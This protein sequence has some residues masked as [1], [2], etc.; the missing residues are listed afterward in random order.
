MRKNMLRYHISTFILVLIL[1]LSSSFSLIEKDNSINK[2]VKLAIADSLSQCMISCRKQE[3]NT[4]TA[5][6]TCKLRCADIP[7]PKATQGKVDCMSTFKNCR[8]S[9]SKSD[10]SCQRTCKK[11]LNTCS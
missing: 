7:I 2:T 11:S 10:R 8:K 9:C 3:G 5:K 6:N 4:S 1:S